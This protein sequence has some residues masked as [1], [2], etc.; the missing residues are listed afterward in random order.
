MIL[1]QLKT[2]D[3]N[4]DITTLGYENLENLLNQAGLHKLATVVR[5]IAAFEEDIDREVEVQELNDEIAR[6]RAEN[7]EL[8]ARQVAKVKKPRKS[9]KSAK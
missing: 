5:T 4:L 3:S 1:E 6:L 8:H 9:K 2:A 7:D